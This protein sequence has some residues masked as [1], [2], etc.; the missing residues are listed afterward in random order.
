MGQCVSSEYLGALD[1]RKLLL[2]QSLL[3]DPSLGTHKEYWG[4]GRRLTES[5]LRHRRE[6]GNRWLRGT[7]TKPSLLPWAPFS[8]EAKALSRRGRV[9]EPLDPRLLRGGSKASPGHRQRTVAAGKR[10]EVK[11]LSSQ[12]QQGMSRVQKSTLIPPRRRQAFPQTGKRRSMEQKS[13]PRNR[14]L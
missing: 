4:Q 8:Y 3:C 9:S 6:E 14:P 11:T 1:T 10:V 13:E 5:P 2:Q 12:G 7:G